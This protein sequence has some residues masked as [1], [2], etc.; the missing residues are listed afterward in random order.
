MPAMAVESGPAAGVIAAALVGRRLGLDNVLSFDMG[1]TTAKASLIERGEINDDVGVRGRRQRQC[2]ALAARHRASDPRAGHRPRRGQRGRRQHR[3]DRSGRRAA[4]RPGERGRRAGPRVLRAGR[5]AAHGHRRR[6][7]AGL[8][9]PRRAAR[10]RA[11]RAPR[12]RAGGHRG[13]TSRGRSGSACSR[14]RPASSTWSTRAW[15]PRSASSRS[16]AA[17]TRAS[18]RWSPSAAPGPCTRRGS[19]RSSRSPRVIVPPIPGGFSALGLVAS[20][21]RRDYVKTFYARAA[22]PRARR[23]WRAPTGRWRPR[24][25]Q[26]WTRAGVPEARWEIA[27]A[28]DLPLRAPGVRADGAV[29]GGRRHARR[30]SRGSAATSTTST[31]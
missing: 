11:A 2:A 5:H 26:C 17:T 1:G 20:D 29:G 19:P 8:P 21:V 15:P 3:V 30:R 22:P 25:G 23:R 4:R 12:P 16:S 6:P 18:S 13:A 9:E 14:R 7:G 27:R 31:G 10:R 24:R 28:A